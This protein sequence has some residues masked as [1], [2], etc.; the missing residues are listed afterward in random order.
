[1]IQ[2]WH[3]YVCVTSKGL[4]EPAPFSDE[5]EETTSDYVRVTMEEAQQGTP[6]KYPSVLL[7][8]STQSSPI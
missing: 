7:L 6:R 8:L 3:H 4:T 2:S 1:M 5:L